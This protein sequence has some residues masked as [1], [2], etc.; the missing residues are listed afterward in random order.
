M[1]DDCQS[2]E[3]TSMMSW[4]DSL[5]GGGSG[6]NGFIPSLGTE[7]RRWRAFLPIHYDLERCHLFA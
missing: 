3:M 6:N 4:Q 7:L 2:G 5:T 1:G